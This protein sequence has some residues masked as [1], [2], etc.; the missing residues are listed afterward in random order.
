MSP[1]SI[2]VSG[3]GFGLPINTS[4]LAAAS[5]VTVSH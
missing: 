4:V 5:A 3:S 1:A 2:P